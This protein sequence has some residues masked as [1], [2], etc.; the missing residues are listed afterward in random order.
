GRVN[1]FL[2]K[3]LNRFKSTLKPPSQTSTTP[4]SKIPERPVS[5]SEVAHYRDPNPRV[6][7]P[8]QTNY[9]KMTID[10]NNSN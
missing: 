5:V 8:Q 6:N 9:K 4:P 1:R 7:T 3:F 2:K 10:Q